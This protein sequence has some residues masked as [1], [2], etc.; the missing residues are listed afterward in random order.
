M[1]CGDQSVKVR[2]GLVPVASLMIVVGMVSGRR[3]SSNQANLLDSPISSS[4]EIPSIL[5]KGE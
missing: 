1:V 4:E 3:S 5:E 2:N